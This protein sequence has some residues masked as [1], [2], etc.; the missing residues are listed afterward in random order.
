M[1]NA[2]VWFLLGA[3]IITVKLIYQHTPELIIVNVQMWQTWR[4]HSAYYSVTE[5]SLSNA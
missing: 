3:R 5:N 1:L 2:F 4:P